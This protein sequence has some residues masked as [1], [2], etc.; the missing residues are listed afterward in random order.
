L[1]GL[2]VLVV[3]SLLSV[4]FSV[5]QLTFNAQRWV[6]I[7]MGIALAVGGHILFEITLGVIS[8]SEEREKALVESTRQREEESYS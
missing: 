8:S 6:L 3:A 2:L 1:N 5:F 7:L 4:A